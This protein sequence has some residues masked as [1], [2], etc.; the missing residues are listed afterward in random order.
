M[1]IDVQGMSVHLI[2]G[3]PMLIT[4]KKTHQTSILANY[5]PSKRL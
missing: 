5:P 1:E 3:K 2:H 4:S